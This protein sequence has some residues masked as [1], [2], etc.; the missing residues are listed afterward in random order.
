MSSVRLPHSPCERRL[1][2]DR[3]TEMIPASEWLSRN[4][5]N[6]L[7]TTYKAYYPPA[8]PRHSSRDHLHDR[9]RE[10]SASDPANPGLQTY[11]RVTRRRFNGNAQAEAAVRC[12]SN[13]LPIPHSM[14]SLI[15][16]PCTLPSPH[17]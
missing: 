3:V 9:N 4:D 11:V 10:F 8:L 5:I 2:G 16:S 7:Q 6:P 17:G 13:K 12:N 14:P 15:L 1:D